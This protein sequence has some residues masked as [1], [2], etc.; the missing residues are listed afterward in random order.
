MGEKKCI[1]VLVISILPLSTIFGLDFNTFLMVL[2]CFHFIAVCTKDL[3]VDLTSIAESD[4]VTCVFNCYTVTCCYDVIQIDR[5]IMS[6][7][8]IDKCKSEM[9]LTIERITQTISLLNYEWG[10]Y[11]V[12]EIN[13]FCQHSKNTIYVYD[14]HT[15]AGPLWLWH[16]FFFNL[17]EFL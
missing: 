2:Y 12:L 11:R 14:L 10:R 7:V 13:W 17:E 5:S 4:N 3:Q 16:D 1:C 15:A 8:Q 9:K 6:S